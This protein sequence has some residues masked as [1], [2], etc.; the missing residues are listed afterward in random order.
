MSN[1]IEK[2]QPHQL[3]DVPEAELDDLRA[4]L[5]GTRWA[6]PWP[7]SGWDAGVDREMRGRMDASDHAPVWVRLRR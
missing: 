4:R 3:L 7:L 6:T 2:A 1:N 5:R